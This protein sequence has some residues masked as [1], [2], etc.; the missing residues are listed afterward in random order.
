MAK[1]IKGFQEDA[2]KAKQRAAKAAGSSAG[3]RK[4]GNGVMDVFMDKGVQ[5]NAFDSRVASWQDSQEAA[6]I[7]KE[8]GDLDS[9]DPFIITG[10]DVKLVSADDDPDCAVSKSLQEFRDDFAVSQW[11]DTAERAMRT[12]ADAD[13]LQ[14][15]T[16]SSTTCC[17]IA[18]MVRSAHP[19]LTP[20]PRFSPRQC[21][22]TLV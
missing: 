20:S 3:Q 10:L 13:R 14:P 18:H 17:H 9:I 6:K 16:S 8:D 19:P 2:Q 4:K 12:S 5:I 22:P 21:C 11:R 7:F 15:T 1:A